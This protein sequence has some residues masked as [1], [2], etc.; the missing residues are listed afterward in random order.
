V[1][2]LIIDDDRAHGES[3]A[4]LLNTRGHEAY[5]AANLEDARWHLGLFSF[6]LALIDY[7]MPERN[8]PEVARRLIQED[9]KL[10]CIVMSARKNDDARREELGDLAFM[11]KPISIDQLFELLIDVM[12]EDA[13]S[14]LVVRVA[15]P[16]VPY[17]SPK[18]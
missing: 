18:K 9:P 15:F 7:D 12:A 5:F 1:R 10:R 2:L 8:G 6:H 17:R 3:L 14:S 13:G 11:A 4:D 16:I